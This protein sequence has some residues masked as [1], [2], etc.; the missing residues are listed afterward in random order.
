MSQNTTENRRRKQ[1]NLALALLLGALVVLFYVI[2]MLKFA[3]HG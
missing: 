1:R 3:N 2:S